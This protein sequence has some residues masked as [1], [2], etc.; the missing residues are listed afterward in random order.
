MRRSWWVRGL[1]F[2]LFGVLGIG[3]VGTAVMLLWNALL[4]A[5]FGLPMIGF[6]Q[7]L[8]VLVLSRILVGGLRGRGSHGHWRGRMIARWEQ[9]SE[10]ERERFRTGMGRRCGGRGSEPMPEERV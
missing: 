9:M 4:P 7:A 1:K 5:L 10:E 8:G 6:W 3:V 2:A